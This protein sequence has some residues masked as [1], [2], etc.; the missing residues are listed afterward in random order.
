MPKLK[1]IIKALEQLAPTYLAESWDN[2][3][4]MVGSPSQEVQKVLCALDLNEAVVDE[5]IQQ[6]VQC[7]VTHHPFLFK[8]IKH[9]NLDQ[10]QGRMI[11]KLIQN[12]IAVYSM[13]T[14]YDVAWGGL[15]DELAQGLGLEDVQLLEKTYEEPLYKCIIYVPETH[16]KELREAVVQHM[17]T[18]IGNYL[19]CTYTSA[20]GEGT[21]IP[22]EGSQPFIGQRGVLE[23]VKE[24]QLSFMGTQAEIQHIMEVV[25]SVHPYEEIAVDQFKLENVKKSY[26]V[27]RYGRLKEAVSLE[28]WLDQVK[29][30]FKVSK[31][32]VTDLAPKKIQ[33]VAICSGSGSDYIAR[34]AKVA[35]VYIT[36][37]LK[38]HEGQMA[39]ALGITVIDV[40]HYASEQI[41]LAP[42]GRKIKQC[43]K[44]CEVLQSKVDG[45]TLH[46]R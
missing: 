1:E 5:A 16:Y 11:A 34:A 15:N 36:G 31:V 39:Q 12:G 32:K 17:E 33:T 35:D 6:K 29:T 26:G 21:F 41:A 25:K 37:D 38:F 13:H 9:I 2:V 46:I 42:I 24:C 4:L 3:G 7:I 40:G 28:A 18:T 30:Y 19:G 44:D 43:F 20:V 45:E 27:G 8:A 23:K 22:L 14:N 10:T